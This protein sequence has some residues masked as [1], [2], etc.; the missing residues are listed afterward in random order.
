[1][2]AP[3][4]IADITGLETFDQDA[5]PVVYF[6]CLGDHVV[7]VGQTVCLPARLN[8]HRAGKM[9]DAVYYVRCR[10]E[11]LNKQEARYI[12]E[13]DPVLNVKKPGGR[14]KRTLQTLIADEH[15]AARPGDEYRLPV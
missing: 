6:L 14:H 5:D 13:L 10:A 9:F 15:F 7:Y 8:E 12:R 4:Q 11:E 1:M 3:D 2:P